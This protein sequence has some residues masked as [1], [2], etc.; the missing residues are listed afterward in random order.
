MVCG[1][2]YS[3]LANP[4]EKNWTLHN[5]ALYQKIKY[6]HDIIGV[7]SRLDTLQ[8]AILDVKIK[9]LDEY[10]QK[11]NA[12]AEY[13]DN[14]L[15][16][17]SAIKIPKRSSYSTHVFH[18]YTLQVPKRDELKKHLEQNGIPTMIY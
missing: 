9:Y 10:A 18:Q 2:A 11:R 16:G 13:Y 4:V 15:S 8:A 6:H 1:C 7:N 5:A 17:V 14:A 3:I 12:V